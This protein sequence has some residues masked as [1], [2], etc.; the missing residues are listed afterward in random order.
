V[1]R[2]RT[3]ENR[4]RAAKARRA[5]THETLLRELHAS[6][7]DVTTAARALGVDK[8]ILYRAIKKFAVDLDAVRREC[9]QP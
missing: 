1:V 2:G 6:S 8:G 3:D 7:G 5:L 9:T 4:G